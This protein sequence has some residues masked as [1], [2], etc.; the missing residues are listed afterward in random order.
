MVTTYFGSNEFS[1]L[2][3]NK[4]VLHCWQ[5][6]SLRSHHHSRTVSSVLTALVKEKGGINTSQTRSKYQYSLVP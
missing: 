1:V 2:I 5:S 6:S 4:F 3:L